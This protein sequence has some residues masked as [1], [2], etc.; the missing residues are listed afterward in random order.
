M[1][2]GSSPGLRL[3]QF[4]GEGLSE[5][6]QLIG[7]TG[8]SVEGELPSVARKPPVADAGDLPVGRRFDVN[9]EIHATTI[10][11][12]DLAP[13]VDHLT[14][15]PHDTD[16][17]GRESEGDQ[18]RIEDLRNQVR[19]TMYRRRWNRAWFNPRSSSIWVA[20]PRHDTWMLSEAGLTTRITVSAKV[21]LVLWGTAEC[22]FDW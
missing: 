11:A 10:W 14:T 3:P 4:A 12:I 16:L 20:R 18:D 9:D 7:K 13:T 17:P 6:G 1:V 2:P 22:L 5:A 8:I 21:V 15:L 19:R